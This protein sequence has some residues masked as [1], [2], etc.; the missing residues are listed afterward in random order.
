M[1]VRGD[2]CDGL[3]I[4][5]LVRVNFTG[6]VYVMYANVSEAGEAQDT[7]KQL[8]GEAIFV[9]ERGVFRCATPSERRILHRY[10][11][12]LNGEGAR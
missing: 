4:G 9:N 8:R 12:G 1:E 7:A 10:Y 5:D 2:G 3:H 6:L 11:Q